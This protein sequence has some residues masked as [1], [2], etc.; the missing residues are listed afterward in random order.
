MEVF[1]NLLMESKDAL[2]EVKEEI[3]SEMVCMEN[4]ALSSQCII[5]HFREN[6]H[7]NVLFDGIQLIYNLKHRNAICFIFYGFMTLS[8]RF[9]SQGSK[10]RNETNVSNLQF[11]K[12]YLSYLRQTLMIDRNLEMIE[13]MKTKLPL[14][15]GQNK[16]TTIKGKITKPEDLIR[17]IYIFLF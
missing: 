8:S 12:T 1:D 14:L 10:K 17:L 2:Q 4:T 13:N 16:Q 6:F 5:Y 11:I 9:F 7:S 15:I 3:S